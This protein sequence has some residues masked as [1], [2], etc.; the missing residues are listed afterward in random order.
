MNM[1]SNVQ[2]KEYDVVIIGGGI[3]GLSTAMQLGQRFPA[4]K[5]A[6]VEK[7]ETLAFSHQGNYYI[8][9]TSVNSSTGKKIFLRRIILER[10]GKMVKKEKKN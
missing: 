6:V 8:S 1:Q 5:I 9:R 2:S 4:Q 10:D 3:L 7:E